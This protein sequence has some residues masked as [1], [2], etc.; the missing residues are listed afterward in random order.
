MTRLHE[1]LA[2]EASKEKTAGKLINEAKKTFGKESHFQGL[3]RKLTMFRDED[4]KSNL[5]EHQALTTTVDEKLEYICPFIGDWLDVVLTKELTNQEARS[6]IIFQGENGEDI[7]VTD[8]LPATFLLGLETKLGRLREL[9]EAIP[10][11]PPGVDWIEDEKEREGVWKTKHDQIQLKTRKD[12]D[13]RK[14]VDATKEHP[15]QVKEVPIVQDIGRY[16]T[17]LYNGMM[18]PKEKALRIARIDEV[19]Q[20]VKKARMRANSVEV[21]EAKIGRSLFGYIN[22]GMWYR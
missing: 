10:T 9:Y 20:A 11:L 12:I 14:V 17:T 7:T 19:L 13:F 8:P 6:P 2:V 1:V 15:A 3:S 4:K 22:E 16:V 21:N 5:E 18:T